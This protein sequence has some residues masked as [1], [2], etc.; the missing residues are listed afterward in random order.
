MVPSSPLV[1]INGKCPS[2]LRGLLAGPR[3]V[4]APFGVGEVMPFRTGLGRSGEVQRR[5]V[6][7]VACG[8]QCVNYWKTGFWAFLRKNNLLFKEILCTFALDLWV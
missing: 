2:P 4:D 3:C 7:R 1:G 5:G 6:V 8:H